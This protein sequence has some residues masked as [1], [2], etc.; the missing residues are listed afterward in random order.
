MNNSIG[1]PSIKILISPILGLVL[2][3][4]FVTS[5]MTETP[6]QK[7]QAIK[8]SLPEEISDFYKKLNFIS[9]A[10]NPKERT[11]LL[12]YIDRQKELPEQ[13]LKNERLKK[14]YESII[15]LGKYELPGIDPNFIRFEGSQNSKRNYDRVFE[16]YETKKNG[17][18]ITVTVVTRLVEEMKLFSAECDKD[19]S[20]EDP[21]FKK[22]NNPFNGTI[23]PRLSKK[24]IHIWRLVDGKWMREDVSYQFP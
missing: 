6:V 17:E 24:E 16:I 20:I 14:V 10:S 8:S 12:T 15:E 11:T 1:R 13:L 3:F 4:L 7:Q 18:K 5:A 2:F 23:A 19:S 22:E 9:C 21:R